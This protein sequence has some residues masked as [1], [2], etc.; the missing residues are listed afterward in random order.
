MAKIPWVRVVYLYLMTTI[1]LV[2][3]IIGSVTIINTGLKASVFKKADVNYYA[4]PTDLYLLQ[5]GKQ[6]EAIKSCDQLT[7]VDKQTIST[8]LSDYK[9]WQES[10]KNQDPV[11]STRQREASNAIAMILVGFPV[12]FLHW[13]IIKKEKHNSEESV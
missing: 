12:Y 7:E 11:T 2:V 6:V 5:S 13:R 1:G 4:Q 3:F 8:W 10:Q 9:M